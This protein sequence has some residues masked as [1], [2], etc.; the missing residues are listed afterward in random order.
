MK[1]FLPLAWVAI[2]A[3]ALTSCSKT[4]DVAPAPYNPVIGSWKI[5]ETS[6]N[7][8]FGWYSFNA[9]VHGVFT[10]YESG[11]ARYYDNY[12]DMVGDWYMNTVT[13]GYYDE[14]GNYYNGP[15]NNFDVYV[16]DNSG[17]YIDLAFDYITFTGNNQFTSTYY[18]GKIVYRYTFARF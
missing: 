8:G 9:K 15:H 4:V 13:T 14:Y 3:I 18:N 16:S 11:T 10:F 1:A 2:F 5:V 7:D 12:N 17:N 6:A